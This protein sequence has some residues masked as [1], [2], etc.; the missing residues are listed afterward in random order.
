M[1][2]QVLEGFY[3]AGQI[4]SQ[5]EVISADD[6]AVL[7]Q[8]WSKLDHERTL[9]LNLP[10]FRLF[11][12]RLQP[13]WIEEDADE[14]KEEVKEPEIEMHV[15]GRRQSASVRAMRATAELKKTG[16]V[17][18]D[19]ALME[20]CEKRSLRLWGEAGTY[21]VH[22]IDVVRVLTRE[23]LARRGSNLPDI[24][25]E[26]EASLLAHLTDQMAWNGVRSMP[27]FQQMLRTAMARR[28]MKSFVH[29][30]KERKAQANANERGLVLRNA[31]VISTILSTRVGMLWGFISFIA[32]L[33]LRPFTRRTR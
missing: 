31:G 11:L 26:Q 7:W 33:P 2:A 13:P 8:I 17:L 24:D 27:P 32:L 19:R 3:S 21:S 25:P 9:Q 16:T 1:R 28:L 4:D 10:E 23:L 20:W 6:M 30:W 22:Y 5:D 14:E 15:L 18:S 12:S 29:N